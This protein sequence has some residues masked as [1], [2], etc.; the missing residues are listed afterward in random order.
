MKKSYRISGLRAAMVS[1]IDRIALSRHRQGEP[2][3]NITLT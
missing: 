1:P 2:R 3:S